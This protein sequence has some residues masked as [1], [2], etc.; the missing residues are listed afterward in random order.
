MHIIIMIQVKLVI[1]TVHHGD[2]D[3]ADT[4]VYYLLFIIFY[5]IFI[6]FYLLFII[7]YL[8]FIIM[9]PRILL[10]NI[11][12]TVDTIIFFLI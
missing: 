2:Y 9:I 5:L 1:I 4:I 6:I 11:Y 7:Y 3:S 8:L 10:F 12:Y